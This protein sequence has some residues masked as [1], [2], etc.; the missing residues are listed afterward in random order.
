MSACEK[1]WADSRGVDD[2]Y[3]I[4][5][6]RKDHPCTAEEQAG[7][8]AGKCPVCGRMT[9]HQYTNEPMCHCIATQTEE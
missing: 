1:C 3:R 2:Y 8:S 4:L 6:S 7:P 9:L 5:E